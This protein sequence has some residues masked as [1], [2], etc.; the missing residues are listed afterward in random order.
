MLS[1][2]GLILYLG[3][4][5]D[6][7]TV[8]PIKL[9]SAHACV[10]MDSGFVVRWDARDSRTIVW[11]I[12][13]TKTVWDIDENQLV[14]IDGRWRCVVNPEASIRIYNEHR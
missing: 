6:I 10:N 9:P 14:I 8:Y 4:G 11:A 7:G 13:K 5:I 1:F 2:F 12:S 3:Y